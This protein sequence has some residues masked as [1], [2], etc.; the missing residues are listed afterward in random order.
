MAPFY[1]TIKLIVIIKSILFKLFKNTVAPAAKKNKALIDESDRTE[2]TLDM[3]DRTEATLDMS[4]RKVDGD[5]T[6]PTS[7]LNETVA[8]V[9]YVLSR[10]DFVLLAH[11]AFLSWVVFAPPSISFLFNTLDVDKSDIVEGSGIDYAAAKYNV[12]VFLLAS[13]LLLALLLVLELQKIHPTTKDLGS[14]VARP[15][16]FLIKIID[17]IFD[18]L[19]FIVWDV[20]D[21]AT[22]LEKGAK[23]AGLPGSYSPGVVEGIETLCL[24]IKN[25][26]VKLHWI[27]RW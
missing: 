23:D 19:P 1:Y 21:P 27:G 7:K 24:S 16:P 12:L 22:L 15:L 10:I 18:R 8:I 13:C 11:I 6:Q 4:D 20:T 17:S 3:S 5:A 2:A 9:A 25:D 14:D 26:N